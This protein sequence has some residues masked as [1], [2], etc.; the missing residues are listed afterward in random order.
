M[1]VA[2]LLRFQESCKN[3]PAGP[4]STGTET[5]TYVRSEQVDTDPHHHGFR[6]VPNC[7]DLFQDAFPSFGTKTRT[8]V[9][10]ESVDNDRVMRK[11]ESVPK[12]I[13]K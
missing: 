13:P 10:K 4:V 5:H 3:A 2:F 6:T 1:T 12:G 7:T 8:E 9:Q 11:F